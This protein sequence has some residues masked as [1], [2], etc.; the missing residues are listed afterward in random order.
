MK[1]R[2]FVVAALG[3]AAVLVAGALTASNMGF[4]LNYAL[5]GPG[6]AG[7]ATGANSL[8]LPYNQQTSILDAEDLIL[9]IAADNGDVGNLLPTVT[10][11]SRFIRT[12]NSTDSYNGL[13]GNN[14]AI[15]PG[16]GY[17]VVINAAASPQVVPY[18]IVGSH[19]PQLGIVLDGPGDNGSATGAQDW[20]YPYH[21]TAATAEDLIN[22]INAAGGI[23]TSI[24]RK[25]RIDNTT[26]SYNGLLGTNF[27][28][29]P[30]E[31][32]SIIIATGG[33]V[34]WTPSH[35]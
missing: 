20:S 15:T 19:D 30:G 13:L 27:P 17:Q 12:N 29:V 35:Y 21:S 9:D 25:L 2:A 22:E 32:Y 24:N 3:V 16:E 10:S 26:Q 28:L 23:V 34:T 5:E 14:F 11:V 6:S 7:S 31:A 33:G 4:K 8:G 18:I 1:K